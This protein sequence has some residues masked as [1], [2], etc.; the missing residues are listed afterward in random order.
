MA[1]KLSALVALV[2]A[3]LDDIGNCA[4]YLAEVP[5]TPPLALPGS[6]D[7]RVGA[8]TVL[9]PTPGAPGPEQALA[10]G[11]QV[12]LEWRFLITCA[13]GIPALVFPLIDLV[14]AQFD[15]WEPVIDGLTVGTCTQDYDPGQPVE[16][17][18]FT[19]SRFYLQMPYRLQVGS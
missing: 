17:R 4:H 9:W 5:Q 7:L 12:D 8:Y 16:G 1:V 19:P 13:A 10:G 11:T 18:G 3:Q 14:R 6:E 15:G 2:Q